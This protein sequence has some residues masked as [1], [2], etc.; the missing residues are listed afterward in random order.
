MPAKPLVGPTPFVPRAPSGA[1]KGALRMIKPALAAAMIASGLPAL[2]R[3]APGPSEP[4]ARQVV[5]RTADLDLSTPEGQATLSTRVRRAAQDLCA[6]LAGDWGIP[7]QRAYKACVDGKIRD[8]MAT[9]PTVAAAPA[10]PK[11]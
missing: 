9:I 6:D 3:A 10:R 1:G 11:G 8:V 5:V 2:A 7:A 4:F